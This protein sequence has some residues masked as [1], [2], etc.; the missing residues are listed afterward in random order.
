MKSL[1]IFIFVLTGATAKASPFS[2][3]SP[4]EGPSQWSSFEN[5]MHQ[6]EERERIAGFGYILSGAIATVG[7]SVG[8]Y[9]SNDPFSRSV[10]AVAQTVGISALGYGAVVYLNGSEY[11]SF[12]HAV[13]G[14][15]LSPGQKTELLQRFLILEKEQR[16]RAQWIRIGTHSILALLNLYASTREEDKNVRGVFQFLGAVNAVMAISYAF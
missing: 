14:S 5:Y 16:G 2:D 6:R 13:Q 15:S 10:Y 12:Y 4:Y 7:G 1:L 8:Y 11:S 3:E 9:S